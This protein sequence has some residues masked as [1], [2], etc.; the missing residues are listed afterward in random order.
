MFVEI[1]QLPSR[2]CA[3]VKNVGAGRSDADFL[4]LQLGCRVDYHF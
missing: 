3:F 4:A 1:F 2:G